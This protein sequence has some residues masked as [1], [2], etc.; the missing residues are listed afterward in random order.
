MEKQPGKTRNHGGVS[1]FSQSKGRPKVWLV[2]DSALCGQTAVISTR[3]KPKRQR[4]PQRGLQKQTKVQKHRPTCT[5][6]PTVLL[7]GPG[8]SSAIALSE[9]PHQGLLSRWSVSKADTGGEIGAV[10]TTKYGGVRVCNKFR[11]DVYQDKTPWPSSEGGWT[12]SPSRLMNQ[13]ARD[14][15]Y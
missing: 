1:F 2:N 15:L 12:D 9:Q 3:L 13:K 4:Q 6:E 10:E 11:T 8:S 7:R 14:K 5:G